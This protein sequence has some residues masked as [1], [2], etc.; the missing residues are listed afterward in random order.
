MS[1]GLWEDV[2]VV[3]KV[4]NA[5]IKRLEQA[6]FGGIDKDKAMLVLDGFIS[7]PLREASFLKTTKLLPYDWKTSTDLITINNYGDEIPS[8]IQA[9]DIDEPSLTVLDS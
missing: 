9:I 5:F 8:T 1:W 2:G 6:G 4:P 7:G 3:N